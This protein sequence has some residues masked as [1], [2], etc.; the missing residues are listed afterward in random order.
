MDLKNFKESTR[1]GAKS[2]VV[3]R[4]WTRLKYWIVP[5]TNDKRKERFAQY[6][7]IAIC[8]GVTMVVAYFED[9]IS[10]LMEIDSAELTR[11]M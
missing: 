10:Q 1:P 4:E 5:P 2:S 8:V 9:K 11:G 3:H 6:K 7:D